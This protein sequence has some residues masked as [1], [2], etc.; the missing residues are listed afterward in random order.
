MNHQ[1]TRDEA[2][3]RKLFALMMLTGCGF[4]PTTEGPIEQVHTEAGR[5]LQA[6]HRSRDFH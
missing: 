2:V 6:R 5:A 1:P 3:M 4:E